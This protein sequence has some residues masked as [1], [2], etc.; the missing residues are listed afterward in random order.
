MA[1]N[2]FLDDMGVMLMSKT[3]GSTVSVDAIGTVVRKETQWGPQ[4]IP[5]YIKVSSLHQVCTSQLYRCSQNGM[6]LVQLEIGY[7]T[8]NEVV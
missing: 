8:S 7:L 4:D 6:T 5:F 2:T 3:R 1:Q